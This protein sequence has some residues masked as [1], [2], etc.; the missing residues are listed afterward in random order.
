MLCPRSSG[1][2]GS[3]VGFCRPFSHLVTVLLFTPRIWWHWTAVIFRSTRRFIMCSPMWAGWGR[4]EGGPGGSPVPPLDIATERSS[5]L[6]DRPNTK[7]TGQP[8]SQGLRLLVSLSRERQLRRSI[9][10]HEKWHYGDQKGRQQGRLVLRGLPL[11][12]KDLMTWN[13]LILCRRITGTMSGCVSP[14][15]EF[16]RG[17]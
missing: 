12:S 15:G 6:R 7:C 3:R 17:G 9:P 16:W 10:I 2:Q 14:I 8:Q 1:L 13:S 4:K 5:R 11:R